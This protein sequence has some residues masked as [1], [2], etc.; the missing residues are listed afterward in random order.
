[1]WFIPDWLLGFAAGSQ[2]HH[3]TTHKSHPFFKPIFDGLDFSSPA[4]ALP[5]LI[6]RT[7]EAVEKFTNPE[8]FVNTCVPQETRPNAF[9]NRGCK[10]MN[11][12][13]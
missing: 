12:S 9:R 5:I 8:Y 11:P 13:D 7:A 1:M 6:S 4:E 10:T 2:L 3:V